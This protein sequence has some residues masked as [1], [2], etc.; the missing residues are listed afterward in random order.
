VKTADHQWATV[1]SLAREAGSA[2]VHV[3]RWIKAAG[4]PSKELEGRTVFERDAALGVVRVHQRAKKGS[5]E[6]RG[7]Q[8]L[9]TA[10]DALRRQCDFEKAK[11]ELLH[12]RVTAVLFTVLTHCPQGEAPAA[13]AEPPTFT[14]EQAAWLCHQLSDPNI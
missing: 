8:A 3:A 6:P 10:T 12:A 9:V 14:A 4:V 1:H 5:P 7:L 11:A 13:P 2:D